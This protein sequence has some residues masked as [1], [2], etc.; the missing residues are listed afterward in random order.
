M[1]RC[2]NPAL[3]PFH[4]DTNPRPSVWAGDVEVKYSAKQQKTRSQIGTETKAAT[5]ERLGR[6]INEIRKLSKRSRG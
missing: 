1:C 5:E 2:L 6:L 3:S 4:W